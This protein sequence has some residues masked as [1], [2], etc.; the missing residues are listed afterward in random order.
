MVVR[1]AALEII[2]S[3]ITRVT[4]FDRREGLTLDLE[5]T[6]IAMI[7]LAQDAKSD[8]GE[9]PSGVQF[10]APSGFFAQML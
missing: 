6:L 5:G 8:G 2:R 10:G 9:H 3:L 7:G 4:V 1:S